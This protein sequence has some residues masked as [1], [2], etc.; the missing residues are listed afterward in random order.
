LGNLL[1]AQNKL[2]DAIS[3]FDEAIELSP[4]FA[5]A[6]RERG[7]AKLLNGDKE[8]SVADAE[9]AV[10]LKPQEADV[11]GQFHSEENKPINIL[12]I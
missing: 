6:Y 7:R 1:I 4:N 11:S 8:G 5:E 9:K 10:E 12:G 2:Q 3:L